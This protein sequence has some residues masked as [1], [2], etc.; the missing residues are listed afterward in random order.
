MNTTTQQTATETTVFFPNL[1]A[2]IK[3]EQVKRFNE[4]MEGVKEYTDIKS[5]DIW[6]YNDV[7]PKGKHVK[8][9]KDIDTLKAYL[10]ARKQK[11]MDKRLQSEL[12]KLNTIAEAKDITSV[13]ISME[14]KKS[15]MWGANPTAEM[16]ASELND[17]NYYVSG[18]ISGCG[19]DKGST[20]VANVLN[21]SNGILKALYALKEAN[22]NTNNRDLF[23]YGAG[24]GI[25]P[26]IEGGVGVSC[27]PAIF[28]KIGMDFKTVASGKTYDVYTITKK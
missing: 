4:F 3:A 9:F 2:A 7:M 20:A 27:Y 18:S 5:M 28:A 17:S 21:Q 11:A 24:Y 8:D 25:C 23:G 1:F 10:I 15:R 13:K 14:W 19:Y 22:I 12:N 16:W 26:Q 6:H